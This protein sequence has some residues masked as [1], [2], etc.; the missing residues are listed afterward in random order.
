MNG[1]RRDKLIFA[2]VHDGGSVCAY[3]WTCDP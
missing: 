1:V 2:I 3:Y